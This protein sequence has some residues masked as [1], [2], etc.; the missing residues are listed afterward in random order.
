MSC[1]VGCRFSS[2]PAL[3]CLWHRLVAA[4]LIR[5]LAWGPPYA[6]GAA[7]EMAERPKKK[8]KVKGGDQSIL[9]SSKQ[10]N[11]TKK[12]EFVVL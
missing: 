2:D 5:P 3:L 7:Q 12:K 8:K 10:L 6:T 1:G 9:L 4:A 11:I